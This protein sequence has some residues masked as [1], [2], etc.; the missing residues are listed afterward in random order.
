MKN[1]LVTIKDQISSVSISDK[2]EL[3][4]LLNEEVGLVNIPEYLSKQPNIEF[5]DDGGR[6]FSFKVSDWGKDCAMVFSVS[7]LQRTVTT[8]IRQY[9]RDSSEYSMDNDYKGSGHS[10]C[11]T[12]AAI[13]DIV[14]KQMIDTALDKVTATRSQN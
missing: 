14:V 11:C 13:I 4:E 6:S 12:R 2:K 3:L 8:K 10:Y 1:S 7:F 9:I 5:S